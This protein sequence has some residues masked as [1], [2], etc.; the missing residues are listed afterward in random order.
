MLRMKFEVVIISI[1]K[2]NSVAGEILSALNTIN[3][4]MSI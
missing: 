2:L 3:W 1:D 4:V